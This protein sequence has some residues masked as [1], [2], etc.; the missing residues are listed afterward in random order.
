MDDFVLNINTGVEKTRKPQQTSRNVS[1]K[2]SGAK[3]VYNGHRAP[4]R[5][6]SLTLSPKPSKTVMGV[7]YAVT[8]KSGLSV[9]EVS[10]TL[11][12]P[13]QFAYGTNKR[14]EVA[15]AKNGHIKT[16]D[17]PDVSSLMR[18]RVEPRIEAVFSQ[19]NWKELCDK[20]GIHSHIT[21]CVL[22]RFKL[23]RLTAIQEAA[24]PPLL[25]GHDCL[26]RAQTGSGKTLAYAVPLFHRLVTTQP[27]I[28]RKDGS[29]ALIILP[30]R[31]LATQ[32]F[33][34]FQ[35]LTNSCVR[36]V[37]GC[38]IGGVSRKSQKVSLRK[39]LN[40]VIGTPQRILDHILRTASLK[41]EKL[42]QLVID[43]ADRLLEMG[44][45]Q[46]IRRIIDHIQ[47]TRRNSS[48]TS[49]DGEQSLQTVLLSATL[50]SGV[51]RL[52]GL[53]LRDPVR[54]VVKETDLRSTAKELIGSPKGTNQIDPTNDTF[55]MP[56]GL[57][58]FLLIVPWKLRLI[59]LAAFLL[60]KCQYHRKRNGKL[61]VFMA[62]QD[63]VDFHH[64]LFQSVLC[65]DD[66]ERVIPAHVSR[67]S[68]F[69]L[70]GKMEHSEREKVFHNFSI[71]QSGVLLTTDVAS[72]GL[73]LASVSWV[74]QYHVTGGP[75]DYVH[76]VGRTAR[77]GG[78]GKAL[79]FL[80]PQELGFTDLLQAHTGATFEQLNL[81]DLM[82]TALF[83]MRNLKPSGTSKAMFHSSY[84]SV[85]SKAT[86]Y[87]T[88]EDGVSRFSH[89]F[90]DAVAEDPVL[91]PL[92]ETAYTSFLR[93]YASFSGE[94]R[95]YFTFKR[96]HLG[97]VARA[98]CLQTTPKQI[99]MRVTGRLS[100]KSKRDRND[101][102]SKLDTHLSSAGKRPRVL[103][104]EQS[105][106][107]A[108]AKRVKPADIAKRN[109]LAEFGL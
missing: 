92:A 23:T 93:A 56:A 97:H 96:L 31:E 36:I 16:E 48:D 84:L 10:R 6:C 105:D 50:T 78:R 4:I 77:A 38:L 64:R 86:A 55:A 45:E 24:L 66:E 42:Q 61:I 71:S 21:S 60:L 100:A 75:V 109:M 9:N 74:V 102:S 22:D 65:A 54:C 95:T 89:M 46:S 44:F 49:D 27:P 59:A 1:A 53:T 73:D 43:E 28:C 82:Q 18:T 69:K 12:N 32:T 101:S 11:S 79:L 63:C 106:T 67:L 13:L 72:R 76:R 52:A 25:K 8:R 39:G 81:P 88:V 47:Q 103:V 29:L 83:H 17:V 3:D 40:I 94:L 51:E 35:T 68:L 7:K 33:E 87:V 70:H 34:V 20:L 41:L 14:E 2:E 98:F 91:S 37:S 57:K 80:E 30:T 15:S 107:K 108:R 26:I 99:A 62:T 90:L 58:H 85:I 5:M 104:F 19:A